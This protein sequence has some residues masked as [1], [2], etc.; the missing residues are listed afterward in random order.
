MG[1]TRAPSSKTRTKAA[2]ATQAASC[3]QDSGIGRSTRPQTAK[4]SRT[5]KRE[6]TLRSPEDDKMQTTIKT[7]KP[8]TKGKPRPASK[9]VKKIAAAKADNG[10]LIGGDVWKT[11]ARRQANLPYGVAALNYILNE[12]D[13]LTFTQ[14]IFNACEGTILPRK[15]HPN[16][17]VKDPGRLAFLL[18]E[19]P[20]CLQ[21]TYRV[22]Q[23]MVEKQDAASMYTYGSCVVYLTS[24]CARI[25]YENRDWFSHPFPVRPQ[26]DKRVMRGVHSP[27]RVQHVLPTTENNLESPHHVSTE[28]MQS[29]DLEGLTEEESLS[30]T[31]SSRITP[32]T[33]GEAIVRIVQNNGLLWRAQHLDRVAPAIDI[34]EGSRGLDITPG[35]NVPDALLKLVQSCPD[36][37]EWQEREARATKASR[38][39]DLT[40]AV[41]LQWCIEKDVKGLFQYIIKEVLEYMPRGLAY[42][43]PPKG[44]KKSARG[45]TRTTLKGTPAS[46]TTSNPSGMSESSG[47]DEAEQEGDVT[48]I[49]GD[50]EDDLKIPTNYGLMEDGSH[51]SEGYKTKTKQKDVGRKRGVHTVA[52]GGPRANQSLISAEDLTTYFQVRLEHTRANAGLR[53]TPL[54]EPEWKQTSD[55]SPQIL[56]QTKLVNAFLSPPREEPTTSKEENTKSMS[57]DVAS[58]LP[59]PDAQMSSTSPGTVE[60]ILPASTGKPTSNVEED[61]YNWR[62]VSKEKE[63]TV[64]AAAAARVYCV[65]HIVLVLSEFGSRPILQEHCTME[66]LDAL[67]SMLAG[68][69][70]ELA[71]A[72]PASHMYNRELVVEIAA[73]LLICRHNGVLLGPSALAAL[74][75]TNEILINE[76]VTRGRNPKLRKASCHDRQNVY[77]PIIPITQSRND[78]GARFCDY[79]THY[80]VGMYFQLLIVDTFGGC[81]QLN[82]PEGILVNEE[83]L[84]QEADESLKG[85]LQ[86]QKQAF[87]VS[88]A[89]GVDFDWNGEEEIVNIESATGLYDREKSIHTPRFQINDVVLSNNTVTHCGGDQ[90][91]IPSISLRASASF[92]LSAHTLPTRPTLA[93]QHALLR[94]LPPVIPR[95][96]LQL[97]AQF[98]EAERVRYLRWTLAS[99][100]ERQQELTRVAVLNRTNAGAIS[101]GDVV[102]AAL[103]A[104]EYEPLISSR[105]PRP[106]YSVP[107]R[108]SKQME[109]ASVTRENRWALIDKDEQ[110]IRSRRWWIKAPVLIQ[111]HLSGTT[112]TRR[113]HGLP[114]QTAEEGVEAKSQL[115]QLK[116]K[117]KSHQLTQIESGSENVKQESKQSDGLKS[118]LSDV[119]APPVELG[120]RHRDVSGKSVEG[121]SL[122]LTPSQLKDPKRVRKDPLDVI[123]Q[124]TSNGS[125]MITVSM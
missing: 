117:L 30:A 77:V 120:K 54:Q 74:R 81:G 110:A 98:I 56:K 93:I 71:A 48:D 68:W 72:F 75:A 111:T 39:S 96:D 70:V 50:A 7:I 46:T 55:T 85:E 99:A 43:S 36:M 107:A 80:L 53:K 12:S 27:I 21:R 24:F 59:P 88:L 86:N 6:E 11:E 23:D 118:M 1:D 18:A 101:D 83:E 124:H 115:V 25:A 108:R 116:L 65:T 79:H 82:C 3:E 114:Q 61:F 16:A 14:S 35:I 121:L 13:P 34:A 76:G 33:I 10:V 102:S 19:I 92:M 90:R 64:S 17:L 9:S 40:L 94:S 2:E 32:S 58:L 41:T 29:V 8:S 26:A 57:H 109:G 89:P 22:L 100:E 95:S 69:L 73:S 104:P 63:L 42:V 112:K 87:T 15:L 103:L 105:I 78:K 38:W 5:R 113:R 60:S 47:C 4:A 66:Q 44:Q 52:A 31:S 119:Q 122:K 84:Q 91:A 106:L 67:A 49:E 97:V 37:D 123:E 45:L 28:A 51:E 62:S 125:H 20:Y